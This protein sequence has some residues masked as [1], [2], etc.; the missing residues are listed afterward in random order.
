[1]CSSSKQLFSLPIDEYP[2]VK[3]DYV[4]DLCQ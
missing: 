4:E 2:I 1:M 3:E